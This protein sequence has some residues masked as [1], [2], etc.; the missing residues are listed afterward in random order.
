MK[1]KTITEAELINIFESYGAYIC[2][3]EIEVTAKECNEN[4]SVLHRGLNAEGWAH[5]FAKKK[6]ISRNAKP[7]KLQ[8]M[9]DTLMNS[10][11]TAVIRFTAFLL[12]SKG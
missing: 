10:L 2:P 1:N 5:L 6:H 7:R 9:M 11:K 3:D 8:V 12:S 4:G